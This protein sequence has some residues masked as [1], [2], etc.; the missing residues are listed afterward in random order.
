[1]QAAGRRGRDGRGEGVQLRPAEPQTGPLHESLPLADD[2]W[3]HLADGRSQRTSTWLVPQDRRALLGRPQL[4]AIATAVATAAPGSLHLLA[5]AS[6]SAAWRHYQQ[7]W[8]ALGDLAAGHRMLMLS[9]ALGHNAFASHIE[10]PGRAL[11]EATAS[12]AA[13]R[14]AILYG[15]EVENFAQAEIDA[16]EV[17]IRFFDRDGEAASRCIER[18]AW[19]LKANR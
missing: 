16:A 8:A 10:A 4:D 17:R 18:Q 7:E 1:M 14:D 15:A 2:V 3:L 6:T 11:H 5:S 12:G 13:S 19:T 9:G